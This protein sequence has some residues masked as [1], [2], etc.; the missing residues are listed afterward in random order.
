MKITGLQLC[1]IMTF[2]LLINSCATTPPQT[3][4]EKNNKKHIEYSAILTD[5][6]IKKDFR[7]L[8]SIAFNAIIYDSETNP[9][10]DAATM[11]KLNDASTVLIDRLQNHYHLNPNQYKVNTYIGSNK[12]DSCYQYYHSSETSLVGK[13]CNE[14]S[15]GFG[16]CS[17]CNNYINIVKSRNMKIIHANWLNN[18][19]TTALIDTF[20][21]RNGEFV[22]MGLDLSPDN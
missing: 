1:F 3:I 20:K 21:L 11:T 10:F 13:K 18:K 15:R 12:S 7:A 2:C 19:E 14:F 4:A 8:K 9:H 6:I 22:F 5:P 17:A 16:A